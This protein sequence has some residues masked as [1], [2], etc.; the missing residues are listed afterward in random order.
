LAGAEELRETL[1]EGLVAYHEARIALETDR[2][3]RGSQRQD[4]LVGFRAASAAVRTA[5]EK[6][7]QDAALAAPNEPKWQCRLLRC[8]FGPLPFRGVQMAPSLLTKHDALVTRLAR[9]AYENR[10][11][12]SGNLD[13]ARL[14]VLA[15]A[16]EEVVLTDAE[17]LGHLRSDGP[18]V[19][20]CWVVDAVLG[21]K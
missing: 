3:A 1:G 11:P 8:I 13:P 14:L 19:R 2:L 10:S 16:L 9:A 20:G 17:V 7:A 5:L 15:D 18:H 6:G 4:R 12:P 21:Q